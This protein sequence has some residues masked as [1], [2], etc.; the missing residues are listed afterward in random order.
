MWASFTESKGIHICSWVYVT[1]APCVEAHTAWCVSL[2]LQLCPTC[3]YNLAINSSSFKPRKLI[4]WS[5]RESSVRA[6]RDLIKI[7][8]ESRGRQSLAVWVWCCPYALLALPVSRVCESI[9]HHWLP[10]S[11]RATRQPRA[12]TSCLA[13]PINL[14]IR[15]FIWTAAW[16]S[17][18][19]TDEPINQSIN[20]SAN[21]WCLFI[22]FFNVKLQKFCLKWSRC[23]L[24]E[25]LN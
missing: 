8:L 24:G 7:Y 11:A 16:S 6:E 5:V 14:T 20:Q 13:L 19:C 15:D 17:L 9:G 4:S 23:G 12:N 21:R 3:R 1:A 2:C 18:Y 10:F 25:E 22:Y